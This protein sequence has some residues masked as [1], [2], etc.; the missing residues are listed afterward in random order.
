MICWPMNIL[1][2]AR[3]RVMSLSS[4]A[5]SGPMKPNLP[6]CGCC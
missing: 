4:S 5:A 6:A 1:L 2:I 3:N